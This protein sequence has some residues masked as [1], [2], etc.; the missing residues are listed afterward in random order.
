MITMIPFERFGG[1]GIK[2]VGMIKFPP[3]SKLSVELETHIKNG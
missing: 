1:E 2:D 3:F